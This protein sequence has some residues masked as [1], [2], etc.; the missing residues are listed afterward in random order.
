[1]KDR[2]WIAF[3]VCIDLFTASSSWGLFF[4]LR[5]VYIEGNAF[6]ADQNFWMGIM[7][8]PFFWLLF[9]MLQGTYHEIRAQFRRVSS[10]RA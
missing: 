7:F 8:L 5:Q 4:Y 10:K 2:L 6:H 9:Y 1:M 3:L